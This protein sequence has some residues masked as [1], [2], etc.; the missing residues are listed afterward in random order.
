MQVFL[1][2]LRGHMDLAL[3]L[4]ALQGQADPALVQE[5]EGGV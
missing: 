3:V 2:A 1:S 5:T 4:S